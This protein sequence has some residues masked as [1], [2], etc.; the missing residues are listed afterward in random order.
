VHGRL[1]RE[2]FLR[3]GRVIASD[4]RSLL[5]LVDRELYSFERVLDFGSG[6]GR[7][8]RN[9]LPAPPSCHLYGTDIDEELVRWCERAMPEVR[10]SLNRPIPP[11]PFDD[12]Q[13]DL[14]YA[15]SVFTHLNEEHQKAWLGELHRITRPGAFLILTVHGEPVI[16][17]LSR[18]ER[19][20]LV[21]NGGFL[22]ETGATGRLKLDGLPDFY[23]TAYH[24]R[25]YID[26]EWTRHFEVVHYVERAINDHQDAVLLRRR[27]SSP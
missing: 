22:F 20:R 9:F 21:H 11:G 8:L 2:S 3:I 16:Q 14:V 1:D 15:I 5:A 6:S 23:Q 25:E 17:Q 27:P 10:W 26:R 4:I 24:T 19:E 12:R 13:F 7:V 18:P